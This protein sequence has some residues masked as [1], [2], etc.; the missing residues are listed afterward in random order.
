M[1]K[2]V[3]IMSKDDERFMAFAGLIEWTQ[4]VIFQSKRIA[5]AEQSLRII[6]AGGIPMIYV[7]HCEH[8]FFVIAANKLLE[9][10]DWTKSLNL[11]SG[12]DFSAIDLFSRQDVTDLRNMREHVVEY[13]QGDGHAKDRW[14][15]DK[16]EYKA[17]ASSCV[18][19]MIGGRLDYVKFAA[20]AVRLLP[21]LLKEPS[22]HLGAIP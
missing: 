18:G 21:E 15:V 13:F 12:V 17:D 6:R 4:G 1:V 9:Y 22:P 10:R 3:P 8:H 5:D 19:T 20:A 7:L 16:P 11:Y 2:N 14:L